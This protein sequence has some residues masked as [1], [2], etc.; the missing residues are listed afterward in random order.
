MTVTEQELFAGY[1]PTTATDHAL[2]VLVEERIR[3]L[4]RYRAWYRQNRW[5]DWP[6]I[7]RQHATEL[8]SLIR[9]ARKARRLAAAAP[10]PLTEAKREA[11]QSDDPPIRGGYVSDRAFHDWQAAGPR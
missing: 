10:D 3:E 4:L 6:D 9:L 7:R 1:S 2:R 11:A 5:A 8:L